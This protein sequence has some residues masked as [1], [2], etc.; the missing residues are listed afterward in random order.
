MMEKVRQSRFNAKVNIVR[1]NTTAHAGAITLL[2]ILATQ[3][4]LRHLP[5]EQD[6]TQGWL[7]GQMLLVS[8]TV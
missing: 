8:L 2:R 6:R 5:K 4:H 3:G 7:D 1:Q